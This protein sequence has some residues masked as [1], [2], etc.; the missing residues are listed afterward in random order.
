MKLK[1]ASAA[2]QAR[3]LVRRTLP[4]CDVSKLGGRSSRCARDRRGFE[5]TGQ[6]SSSPT[7][8]VLRL[9]AMEPTGPARVRL[10]L[11]ML[12]VKSLPKWLAVQEPHPVEEVQALTLRQQMVPP[13]RVQRR[14]IPQ[15]C[16]RPN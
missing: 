10:R 9:R 15:R 12:T 11:E 13:G 4:E 1:V 5:Q 2:T 6:V 3:T 14:E 16:Y 7:P 8:A